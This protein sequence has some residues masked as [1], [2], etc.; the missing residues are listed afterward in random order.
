[1]SQVNK[2]YNEQIKGSSLVGVEQRQS[3]AN[4]APISYDWHVADVGIEDVDRAVMSY[5]KG[6]S[7]SLSVAG[8]NRPI[9]IIWAG[10]ERWAAMRD[11]KPLLDKAGTLILPQISIR[12]TDINRAMQMYGL[13]GA[14]QPLTV[15]IKIADKNHK[16]K[17]IKNYYQL[18]NQ[19]SAGNSRRS[20][21]M[22]GYDKD[23]D[24]RDNLY[25]IY[26]VPF[27][28]FFELSY[29]LVVWT[30]YLQDLNHIVEKIIS[31]FYHRK[32]FSA[33]SD[34]GYYFTCI[35]EDE[36]SPG[37]N[38]EDYSAEERMIRYTMTFKSNGFTF[39]GKLSEHHVRKYTNAPNIA[40]DTYDMGSG[41]PINVTKNPLE[42]FGVQNKEVV[43]GTQ[44]IEK[45]RR[46]SRTKRTGERVYYFENE[47]QLEEFFEG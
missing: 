12:R 28:K 46:S 1:M 33:P 3:K 4:D 24:K 38:F 30:Q 20:S 2:F 25:D 36:I 13:P 5:F 14:D 29:E 21:K 19:S 40:F 11:K 43:D 16:Y 26:V 41:K 7:M 27:P 47:E 23:L 37:T 34:K 9:P 31:S 45:R 17:N 42:L 35:A 22:K 44:Q 6:L 18:V 8:E 32:M 39:G 10:S 15:K